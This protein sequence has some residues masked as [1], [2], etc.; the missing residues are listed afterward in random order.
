MARARRKRQETATE[1]SAPGKSTGTAKAEPAGDLAS[2]ADML[3]QPE[4]TESAESEERELHLV[5]FSLE[6]E[7]Y[8]VPI[9]QVREILRVPEIS[10]VPQ[11]PPHVRGV[12]NV[13]GQILPVVEIRTRLGLEPLEIEAGSRV[14]LAEVHERVVGLLVDSVSQVL[15]IPESVLTGGEEMT[16]STAE[17]VRG[18][19]QFDSRLIILLDMEQT[20]QPEAA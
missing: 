15:R 4:G 6:G 13:R 10:R 16:A 11:A 8:G 2:F 18:L 19:A 20:L 12:I 9:R 17:Y 3:Q 5:V 1:K 7:E 14:L